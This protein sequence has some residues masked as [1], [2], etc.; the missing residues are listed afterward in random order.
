MMMAPPYS[1][2]EPEAPFFLKNA[3]A[4]RQEEMYTGAKIPCGERC[5]ENIN[6][7]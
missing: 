4:S 1:K 6:V 5:L 7:L 3:S 2:K